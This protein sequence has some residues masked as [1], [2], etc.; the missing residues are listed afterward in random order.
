MRLVI[1]QWRFEKIITIN[2]F[3]WKNIFYI[4]FWTLECLNGIAKLL[5]VI[6]FFSENWKVPNTSSPWLLWLM[7]LLKRHRKE[8]DQWINF[9][10][11]SWILEF[12]SLAKEIE[13][14]EKRIETNAGSEKKLSQTLDDTPSKFDDAIQTTLLTSFFVVGV[15]GNDVSSSRWRRCE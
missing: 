5:F 1:K 12:T 9:C 2:S 15:T 7:L 3:L 6:V 14:S 8:D 10:W 4:L 13:A 11:R